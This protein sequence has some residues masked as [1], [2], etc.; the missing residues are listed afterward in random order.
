MKGGEGV[1]IVDA[2]GGTIDISAYRKTQDKVQKFEEVDIP[3]SHFF[4]SV[5]VSVQAKRF[6][7]VN[8]DYLK[9]SNFHEDLEHIVKCFDK[10]TKVRFNSDTQVE[11]VKFG[12]TRDNDAS[13]NIRYG[14]LKLPGTEIAKFF[15]PSVKCIVDAVLGLVKQDQTPIRY[16]VLVGGFAASE[17]LTRKVDQALKPHGLRVFRPD[18]QV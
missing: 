6:L 11:Y 13:C 4:G 2:G 15:K 16:V 7:D 5:F 1:I 3:Q 12:G 9:D 8:L 18:T 17:W 10:S 14:Q